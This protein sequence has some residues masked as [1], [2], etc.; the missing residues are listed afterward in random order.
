M[1]KRGKNA[2]ISH[3]IFFAVANLLKITIKERNTTKTIISEQKNN[4]KDEQRLKHEK[5]QALKT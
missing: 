4:K 3:R 1:V 2:T 5:K